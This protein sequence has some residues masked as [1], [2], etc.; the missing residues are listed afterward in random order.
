[1]KAVALTDHGTVA[2]LIKFLKLCRREGI[3]PILG[4]EAYQSRSHLHHSKKEQPEGSKGNKHLIVIAKNFTGYQNL[5]RIAQEAAL[6][7]VYYNRPRL[8]FELLEKYSEGLIISSA[9][10]QSVINFNLR[11]DNYNG[12]RKAVGLFKDIFKDDFYLEMMYHGIDTEAKI[13][14]DI[15]KLGKETDVKLIISNDNH[16]IDKSDSATQEIVMCMSTKKSVKDPKR[17]RFPY[18]EFYFKTKEEMYKM[19]SHIPS[20]LRNTVEIAEKCDYSELIFTEE[21]GAMKLP[22]F[23]SPAEFTNPYEYVHKL[24][25]DGLKK[26]KLDK[27]ELHCQQL[28]LELSDIK[29]IYETKKYDF[30]TYFLIVYD[31]MEYARKNEIP[32]GVRGSGCGSVLLY[33]LGI[34]EV[35]PIKYKLLWSRFLGFESKKFISKQDFGLK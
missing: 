9:C 1:M 33:C 11:I 15:Q 31:I 19:F 20:A 26:L 22:S 2:G 18:G 16:C 24:A 35:D 10:L 32:C 25:Y 8:D 34:H 6:H 30:S 28:A 3:K 29:M 5:C 7:G 27:S 12:A 14:P 4:M 17:I 23:S 13:L 21:G